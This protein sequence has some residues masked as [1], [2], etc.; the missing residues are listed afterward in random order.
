MRYFTN[1]G[2]GS[3]ASLA[4]MAGS[5]FADATTEQSDTIPSGSGGALEFIADNKLTPGVYGAALL[6]TT[7][8]D[9][10]DLGY[11]EIPRCDSNQVTVYKFIRRDLIFYSYLYT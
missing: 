7:E 6:A 9:T 4:S 2:W 1:L 11:V 3:L 8:T 10:V 5:A